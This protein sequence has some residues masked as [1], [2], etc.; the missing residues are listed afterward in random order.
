MI[1]LSHFSGFDGEWA[2]FLVLQ[3]Q[4]NKRLVFSSPF[5]LPTQ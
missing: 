5:L 1:G 2:A 3:H 4:V